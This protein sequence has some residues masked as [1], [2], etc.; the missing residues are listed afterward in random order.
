[1]SKQHDDLSAT[2]NP[3]LFTGHHAT[4]WAVAE[5]ALA[6]R[7]AQAEADLAYAEWCGD[8]CAAAYAVY[9]AAQDRA[10]AAQ[11]DLAHAWAIAQT[12]AATRCA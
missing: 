3:S 2:R 7:E 6:R 8:L 11:D 5:L 9:R 4:L 1:M 10:D 12:A